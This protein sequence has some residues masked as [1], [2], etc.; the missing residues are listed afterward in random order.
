MDLKPYAYM[1]EMLKSRRQRNNLLCAL[2]DALLI[3]FWA[4]P[5]PPHTSAITLIFYSISLLCDQG[6]ISS[7]ILQF[8][9]QCLH[10]AH[11]EM[12]MRSLIICPQ[13][14]MESPQPASSLPCFSQ[15]CLESLVPCSACLPVSGLHSLS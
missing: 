14:K 9:L 11:F 1:W 13:D 15:L 4:P 3:N 5:R 8:A 7:S 2:V 10:R 6:P 12:H